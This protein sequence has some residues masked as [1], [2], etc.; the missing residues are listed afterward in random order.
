[1]IAKKY[2]IA[3]KRNADNFL[4]KKNVV[5]VGAGM[6]S[7]KDC[8]PG[9]KAII[10]MVRKKEDKEKLSAQD[11]LPETVLAG[12][13]TVRVQVIEVGNIKALTAE[14]RFNHRPLVAGVSCGHF[15]ITAG[16]LGLFVEKGGKPYILSNN[17]VIANSNTARIGDPIYQPG[18]L[19]GGRSRHTVA[20]LAEYVPIS[21]SSD[22]KVDA[23]LA[24]IVGYGDQ[25][26]P[27]PIQ[28]PEPKPKRLGFFEK[29]WEAI[30]SFFRKIFGRSAAK[31]STTV[32]IDGKVVEGDETVAPQ[33]V[34][35]SNTM[36]NM[37]IALTYE[38]ADI[39]EEYWV[40]KS[41]RTTGY[42]SAKV[43]VLGATVNVDFGPGQV[44]RFVD[45]IIVNNL[46]DGGDSG[47]AVFDM[48]GNAVG[49][50]FAGSESV[51]ICS[52]MKTVFAELG[53]DRI[54][55]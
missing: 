54:W 49:L 51:T 55:R 52:P 26:I 53:I 10:V 23:A 5:G 1:M 29:I 14:H 37:P 34:E 13:E 30:T 2:M 50:L 22:N 8:K 17:H 24:L 45:Q 44:A 7:K 39:E 41:G 48:D 20:H 25:P 46:S 36:L 6:C 35:F 43:L 18:P 31:Q 27:D 33:S 42:T 12:K 4:N 38:L 11:L 19:D 16:T 47:S 3:A 21:F 15:A 9:E 40:Q 32:I 28:P